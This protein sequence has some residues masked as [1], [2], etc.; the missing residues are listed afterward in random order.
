[1]S[2]ASSPRHDQSERTE[3]FRM[4]ASERVKLL[5][6]R[7]RKT[8]VSGDEVARELR[9][10]VLALDKIY[11]RSH[12]DE[13]ARWTRIYFGDPGRWTAYAGGRDQALASL[14]TELDNAAQSARD[15]GE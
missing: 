3:D 4:K 13:A 6:D 10:L 7:I 8:E 5:I 14:L 1:M 15:A 2:S 9:R 12:I 11:Y